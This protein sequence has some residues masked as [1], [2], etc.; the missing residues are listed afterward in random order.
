MP[1]VKVYPDDNYKEDEPEYWESYCVKHL[2]E[3]CVCWGCEQE[4]Q[5][6]FSG[7]GDS[8]WQDWDEYEEKE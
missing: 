3:G 4:H 5:D 8:N 1:K 7:A 2:G 6:Y